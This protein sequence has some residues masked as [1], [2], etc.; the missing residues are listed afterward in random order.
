M[1]E[2]KYSTVDIIKVIAQLVSTFAI[3]TM[4]VY[5]FFNDERDLPQWLTVAFGTAIGYWLK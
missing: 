4:V 2:K 3:F 1:D 5:G